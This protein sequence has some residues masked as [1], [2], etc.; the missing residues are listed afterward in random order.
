MT[1]ASRR[2]AATAVCTAATAA[3]LGAVAPAAAAA[4]GGTS[5]LAAVRAATAQF[6]DVDRALAAGY[7][8]AGH[9]EELPGAGGMGIHYLHPQLA[10]D[11]AVDPL[12]P[13]VLLYE[14]TADGRLR[15]V[16]VEYFVADAGQPRPEV[17]GRPFD[18]PMAGHGPGMPTH[19]DLHVWLWRHNKAGMTAAW[20]PAVS[21]ADEGH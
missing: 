6:H 7:V 1:P 17:L 3:L 2:T 15:L 9:C 5:D 10:Q 18:G 8:P 21:C 13:E 14:P 20:N 4:P 11:L 16:G 19:Y 12:R